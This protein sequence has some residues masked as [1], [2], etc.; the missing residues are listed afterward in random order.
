[1]HLRTRGG[2]AVNSFDN[3]Q[4]AIGVPCYNRPEL[5]DRCLRSLRAQSYQNIRIVISD[6]ASTDPD[7]GAVATRH[8][9]EDARVRSVRQ[10]GNIGAIR[11]FEFVLENSVS[12]YFMWSSDDDWYEPLSHRLHSQ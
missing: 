1:M 2:L 5:L 8:S 10:D 4:V 9:A 7:V 3:P 12:P 11:N 6:N